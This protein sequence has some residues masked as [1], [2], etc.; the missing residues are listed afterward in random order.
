[1]EDKLWQHSECCDGL[2]LHDYQIT[3]IFPNG[4]EEVCTRCR[5]IKFFRNDVPNS[6]YLSYHLKMALQKD[7]PRFAYEYQR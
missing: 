3:R 4:V 2:W 7:N 5:D 1:M 6:E